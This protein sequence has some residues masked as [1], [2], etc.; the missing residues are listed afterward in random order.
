LSAAQKSSLHIALDA[1][2]YRCGSP[3]ITEMHPNT[4]VA[5]LFGKVVTNTKLTCWNHIEWAYYSKIVGAK[6]PIVCC[7]C[8]DTPTSADLNEREKQLA[9]IST[10]LPRCSGVD[11]TQKGWQTRGKRRASAVKKQR[12]QKE[13]KSMRKKFALKS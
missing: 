12:K 4:S 11:C 3:I 10:C 2:D 1:I 6:F 13:Q 9:E 7:W 8:G 5:A